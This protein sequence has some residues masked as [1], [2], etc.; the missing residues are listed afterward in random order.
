[1][2]S[3]TPHFPAPSGMGLLTTVMNSSLRWVSALL[4]A[5]LG[6]ASAVSAQQLLLKPEELRAVLASSKEA[7][8]LAG[9]TLGAAPALLAATPHPIATIVSQG[10]VITDPERIKSLDCLKDMAKIETLANAWAITEKP[11]YAAKAREF[12]LAWA[13]VNRS[14]GDAI[15]DTKLEPMLLAYDLLQPTFSAQERAVVEAWMRQLVHALA[16]LRGFPS[17]KFNNNYSHRLKTVGLCALLLRD[18]ERTTQVAQLFET[19]IA[20]N[21]NPDGSSFDFHERDA[22]YYHC[23][24]LK[25]LLTL[26]TAFRAL[27]RD[28]Y[29]HSAP[30]GSSLGASVRFLAQFC[31]GEKTHGEFVNSRN[32][33]D[34]TRAEA[35]DPSFTAGRPF[36]PKDGLH[37][38]EQASLFDPSYLPLVAKLAQGKDTRFPTWQTVINAALSRPAAAP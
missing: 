20:S 28:F 18:A 7:R 4:V 27:G 33:F 13:Q 14:T 35:G 31:T 36:D 21:L 19:Q 32:P 10:R 5:A 24:D 6:L 25:P 3:G 16:T 2:T 30:G 11:E 17:K 22:L 8:A 9:E 1:M 34:K 26:A 12:I 23:Y 37:V 29:H 15:N 38:L